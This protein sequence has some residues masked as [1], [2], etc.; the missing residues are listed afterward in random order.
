MT[1]LGRE[2]KKAR[3]ERGLMQ[4]D[5]HVLTGITQKYL[6]RIENDKADPSF[7]LVVRIAQALGIRL[8]SLFSKESSPC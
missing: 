6:S 5:L 7:S 2:I 4:K 3:A 1:T 8:D